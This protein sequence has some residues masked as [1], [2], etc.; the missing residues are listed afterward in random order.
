MRSLLR[1][2]VLV[3]CTAGAAG[4]DVGSWRASFEKSYDA[5]VIGSG[6]KESLLSSLL[7]S[8]GKTVLQLEPQSTP[9]G[10]AASMDLQTLYERM[11]APGAKPEGKLKLGASEEYSVD[12]APKVLTAGGKELQMLVASGLWQQMD[13]R[14]VHLSFLYRTKPDGAC[15][16]HR[17]LVTTE[18]VV[19]TRCLPALEKPKVLLMLAWLDKFDE[20]NPTSYVA[21]KLQKKRLN[22]V[23]MSSASFFRY[24]DFAPDTTLLMACGLGQFSA[25]LAK[26]KKLP[27]IEMV[28]AM[29]RYKESFKTFQY[30][31]SPYVY[32]TAGVGSSFA[33][34]ADKVLAANEGTA[35]LGRRIDGIL[36]D[37]EGRACGVTS[38]GVSVRAGCVVAGP[39]HVPEAVEVD[40]TVV[41]LYAV[42]SH[43]PNK[44]KDARSCRLLIPGSQVGRKHDIHL[45]SSGPAHR[46]APGD[47]WVAVLS[48]R[49]E[50]RTEG[51]TALEVRSYIYGSRSR[52]IYI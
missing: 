16:V 38:D 39:E 6:P 21:G 46:I 7:A 36:Y 22:L 9:G 15:D 35:L 43:A 44:C 17:V 18:D 3:A 31:T 48:T 28:R 4:S 5:V 45:V 52:S 23:K 47:K 19:K 32:P 40:Y 41:R 25:P 12:V 14:R 34:A 20:S 29:K 2:G 42:L 1:L 24:W 26:L 27:A 11:G 33:K 49:V 13:F 8:N 50:G 30:M 51:L 10:V 37:A